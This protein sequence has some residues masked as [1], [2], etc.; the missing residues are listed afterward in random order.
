REAERKGAKMEKN[1][2]DCDCNHGFSVIFLNRVSRQIRNNTCL[3]F[4]KGVY[5]VDFSWTSVKLRS[6]QQA[7]L[8]IR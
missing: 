5:A 3:I 2:I 6:C 7:K 8:R 1:R 4:L